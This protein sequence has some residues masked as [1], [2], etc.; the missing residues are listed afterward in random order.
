MSKSASEFHIPAERRAACAVYAVAIGDRLGL[1]LDAL[2]RL[3]HAADAS[4]LTE[5]AELDEILLFVWQL[6]ITGTLGV[7]PV[8]PAAQVDRI[9]AAYAEV[10][11]VIQPLNW[12]LFPSQGKSVSEA[13]G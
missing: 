2:K 12:K 5:D 13:N 8:P 9:G 6:Q 1:E 10:A 4:V 11:P 3:R 7:V